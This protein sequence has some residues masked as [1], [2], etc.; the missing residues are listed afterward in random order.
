M[1]LVVTFFFAPPLD[2]VPRTPIV[3]GNCVR[4]L[5][6]RMMRRP[7]QKGLSDSVAPLAK[8]GLRFRVSSFDP[9]RYFVFR[10]EGGAVGAFPTHIGDFLGCGLPESLAETRVF[11]EHRVVTMK[12]RVSPPVHVG[13]EL[14]KGSNF[15]VKLKQGKFTKNPPPSSPELWA[16]RRQ[17]VSP[18]V[19]KWHKRRSSLGELFWLAIAPRTGI[20]A[21]LAWIASRVNP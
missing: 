19:I 12:V 17:L 11:P 18:E 21:S 16:V 4:P 8:V 13:M 3:C 14:P 7:L 20:R 1:D 6:V 2:G 5:M 9:C 15:S 10:K